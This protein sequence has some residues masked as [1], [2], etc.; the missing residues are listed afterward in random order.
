[1]PKLDYILSR[2]R[3]TPDERKLAVEME[4]IVFNINLSIHPGDRREGAT[5]DQIKT[6]LSH[7]GV[8]LPDNQIMEVLRKLEKVQFDNKTIPVLTEIYGKWHSN[9]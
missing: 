4:R 3:F 6:A 5:F 2:G 1:M 7:I 9:V 8:E